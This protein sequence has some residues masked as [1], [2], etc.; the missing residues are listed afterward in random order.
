[1][2][3]EQLLRVVVDNGKLRRVHCRT[4]GKPFI[5][6]VL[7][8]GKSVPINEHAIH[9]RED[10]NEETFVRYELFDRDADHRVTCKKKPI[11]RTDRLAEA[12]ARH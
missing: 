7:P 3:H 2:Y 6:R 10:R 9:V 4:C 8:N 11:T 1:M 12:E 5:W